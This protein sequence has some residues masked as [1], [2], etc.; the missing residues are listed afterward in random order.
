MVDQ[1]I[2]VLAGDVSDHELC[3]NVGWPKIL[4][5]F[6]TTIFKFRKF[7]SRKSSCAI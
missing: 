2:A 4:P 6:R 5:K 7:E 3:M 1:L